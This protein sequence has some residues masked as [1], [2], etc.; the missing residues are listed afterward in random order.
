M[1]TTQAIRVQ[2]VDDHQIVRTGFRALLEKEGDIQVVAESA[3]GKQAC[4]DYG[5]HLPDILIM[6]ISLPDISGLEAM[7]RILRNHPRARVLVL[8]M[9]SGMVAERALQ[10]GARGFV[11]KQSSPSVLLSAIHRIMRGGR[12]MDDAAN[13]QLVTIPPAKTN[14]LPH[15][16]SRRELEICMLLTSGKNVTKIAKTLYLSEK[17]VYTHR[18]HIMDKLGVTTTIKLAQVATRMGI[19]S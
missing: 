18:Q 4:L 14:K 8:S 1:T 16:L 15:P 19:H 17:T 13:A 12:Y 9:H 10:L 7:R 3:S 11:C 6:D 5:E 2:L